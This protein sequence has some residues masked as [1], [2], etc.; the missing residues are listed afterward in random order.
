MKLC[1]E[2]G[3]GGEFVTGIAYSIRGQLGWHQRT[4]VFSEA[5]LPV[6]EFA[7]KLCAELGLGGEFVTGIAYSIRGQLGW[8]QRTYVFSEAPLP[9]VETPYRVAGDAEQW[10]PFLE[11]LTDAEMEKKIRDQDRNT[12]RMRRLANTTPDVSLGRAVNRMIQAD[13]ALFAATPEKRRKKI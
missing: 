10:A 6:V 13:Q 1:A 3:L 2:L 5:P 11:T 12:R 7:M 8:H 4:Y 9:V